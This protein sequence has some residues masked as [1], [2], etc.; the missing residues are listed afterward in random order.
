MDG[1]R[2]IEG[3]KNQTCSGK[4]YFAILRLYSPTE[5]AIT[6]SW[7]PSDIEKVNSVVK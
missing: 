7:K 4:G 6:K 3:Y 2:K 1:R 5:A